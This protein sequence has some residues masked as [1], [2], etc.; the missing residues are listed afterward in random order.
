MVAHRLSCGEMPTIVKNRNDRENESPK[1]EVVSSETIEKMKEN[2]A[3]ELHLPRDR[4]DEFYNELSDYMNKRAA[5]EKGVKFSE[6][7]ILIVLEAMRMAVI[8]IA[9]EAQSA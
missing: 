7:E 1:N 4:F 8:D 3:R 5:G 6:Y 2:L 9:R